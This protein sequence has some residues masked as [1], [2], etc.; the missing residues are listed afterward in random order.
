MTMLSGFLCQSQLVVLAEFVL[1]SRVDREKSSL[2][3]VGSGSGDLLTYASALHFQSLTGLDAFIP[4]D[5]LRSDG[6][7][8][9]RGTLKEVTGEKDLIMF[10]HSFEH[11]ENPLGTL[12]EVHR[13]LSPKGLCMIRVPVAGS[14]ASEYY[15][16]DWVQLDVPRHLTIPSER[17]L[18]ECARAAGLELLKVWY[19]SGPFQ[20]K[21]SNQNARRSVESVESESSRTELKEY[22]PKMFDIGYR[23]MAAK[24][25]NRKAGDQAAFIFRTA[26]H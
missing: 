19:D 1:E 25:N 26:N 15:K 8:V 24:L 14:Q 10:N 6:V 16:S 23:I 9:K 13:I 22:G 12:R 7:A 11:F 2:V 4:N 17:G 3:D 5:I 18:R 20:F 21:G